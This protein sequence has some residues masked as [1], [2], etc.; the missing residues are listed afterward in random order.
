MNLGVISKKAAFRVTS[1][2]EVIGVSVS[3]N[4]Q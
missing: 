2:E 3:E 4:G 1:L